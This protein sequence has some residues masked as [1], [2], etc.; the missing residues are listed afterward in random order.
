MNLESQ[1]DK[2]NNNDTLDILKL[3]F[4]YNYYV[5]LIKQI[6]LKWWA[7]AKC[8]WIYDGDK[9]IKYFHTLVT[10]P[11]HKNYIKGIYDNNNTLI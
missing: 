6:I 10:C 7:K 4:L 11:R 5:I 2:N 9:N 8:L 3:S 1:L